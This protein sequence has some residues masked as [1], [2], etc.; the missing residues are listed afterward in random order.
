MR[1]KEDDV[2]VKFVH[3]LITLRWIMAHERLESV[4]VE[5]VVSLV[6]GSVKSQKTAKSFEQ[7]LPR[8]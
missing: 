7:R 2:A 1:E 6:L 5:V 8:W 4:Q 3:A